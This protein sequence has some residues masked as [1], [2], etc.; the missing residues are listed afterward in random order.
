MDIQYIK[1][2]ADLKIIKERLVELEESHRKF[3]NLKG[4]GL[5]NGNGRGTAIL[6]DYIEAAIKDRE[7]ELIEAAY[8]KFDEH[9]KRVELLAKKEAATIL[10]GENIFSGRKKKARTV[11]PELKGEDN[12]EDHW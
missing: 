2:L 5:G 8:K 4:I 9:F 12:V 11:D 1:E 7:P 3:E 6:D 10:A